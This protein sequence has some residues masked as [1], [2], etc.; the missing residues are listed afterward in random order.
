MPN[1]S[2][3][4]FSHQYI[5]IRDRVYIEF[6][7]IILSDQNYGIVLLKLQYIVNLFIGFFTQYV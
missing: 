2:F 1:I 5:L 4:N 3:R 7:L 6:D